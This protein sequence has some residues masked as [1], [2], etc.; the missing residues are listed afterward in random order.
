[1]RPLADSAPRTL[2]LILAVAAATWMLVLGVSGFETGWL[3]LVPALLIAIPLLA[4]RYPGE[5]VLDR[6]RSRRSAPHRRCAAV[7]RPGCVGV[8]PVL[9]RGGLLLAAGLGRRG[10]PGP[11]AA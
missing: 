5:H 4:G 2:A 11:R 10:P 7:A 8:A 9:P 1:M 3:Y 6:L